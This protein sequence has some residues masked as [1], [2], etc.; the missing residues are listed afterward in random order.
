MRWGDCDGRAGRGRGK[1][2]G[3][4]SDRG[5]AQRALEQEEWRQDWINIFL[6]KLTSHKTAVLSN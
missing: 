5:E 2:G 4:H 6:L 1:H 3:G